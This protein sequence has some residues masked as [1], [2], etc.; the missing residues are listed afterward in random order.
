MK[1]KKPDSYYAGYEAQKKYA[2]TGECYS[3]PFQGGSGDSYQ[4]A[5]GINDYINDHAH[6]DTASQQ[7]E[8]FAGNEKLQDWDGKSPPPVGVECEWQDKNTQTWMGVSIV[9]SSEWV[10][11]IRELKGED[12]VEIAI[13]NYGDED[14]RVFRPIRTEAERKRED[15]IAAMR[16]F[17]TNYNNS[18]VIHAIEKMYDSIAAGKI[19][20]IKLEK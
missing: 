7:F 18:E 1:F 12:A 10:T 13:E 4:F 8:S 15:S 11:V 6:V 17:A 3:C 5:C 19:P 9:Y 20:H 2:E 16:N 14:R